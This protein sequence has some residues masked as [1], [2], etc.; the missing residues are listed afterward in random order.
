LT[1]MDTESLYSCGLSGFSRSVVE[2]GRFRMLLP[3]LD[4]RARRTTRGEAGRPSLVADLSDAAGCRRGSR[5]RSGGYSFAQ[6]G[7]IEGWRVVGSHAGR[8]RL[9]DGL[10]VEAADL[11]CSELGEPDRAVGPVRDSN[12][13]RGGRAE[14]EREH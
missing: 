1:T 8:N 7:G 3:G 11:V 10:H 14:P 9:A 13:L 6:L 12:R 2:L 5:S 4:V